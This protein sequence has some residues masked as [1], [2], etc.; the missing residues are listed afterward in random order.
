MGS[1]LRPIPTALLGVTVA[2]EAV[3]VV[4]AW[5]LEPAYDTF[6]WATVAIATAV[7][8][9]LVASAR[10]RN[11]IGWLLIALGLQTAV[12]ADLAQAY[13]LR[14][15]QQGWPW[16][17]AAEWIALLSWLPGG[18]L[19]I[20]ALVRFPDGHLPAARWRWVPWLAIVGC[21]LAMPGWGMSRQLG[22]SLVGGANPWA[23]RG[24]VPSALYL[25]GSVCLLTALVAAAAALV[26]R[27]RRAAGV[28]RQQLKW[29]AFAA[30]V[31]GVLLPVVWL[32]WGITP[33]VAGVLAAAALSAF[34]I[35]AG[36]AVLRY[37]LYDLDQVVNRALVY[38]S[39]TALL[40]AAYALTVL[41]V[42]VRV[43]RD[44]PVAVATA[45]LV[46]A[47]A[48][49]PVRAKLQVLVDRRFSRAQWEARARV[50]AFLED[51]RAGRSARR[52]SSRYSAKC[53]TTGRWRC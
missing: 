18:V 14:A 34:P 31:A 15:A 50:S 40:G 30:T 2:V 11:P 52:R 41:V 24:P 20:V 43:G 27:F 25:V 45:T 36:I 47:V 39:M 22:A 33:A 4:L 23:V 3:A 35:A 51:V 12:M 32:L 1:F 53:S 8:G 10:P 19:L 48:F 28:E 13:G 46:V 29:V 17:E 42:G 9:A 6:A 37:R 44:S 49:A 21:V 38:A 7:M 26:Q 16:G 5:S